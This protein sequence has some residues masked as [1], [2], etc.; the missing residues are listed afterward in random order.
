[1]YKPWN[2]PQCLPSSTTFQLPAA[3]GAAPSTPAPVPSPAPRQQQPVARP[4]AAGRPGRPGAGGAV[5]GEGEGR[6]VAQ[7]RVGVILTGKMGRDQAN[8]VPKT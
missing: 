5:G 7:G 1:M 6:D 3:A 4:P 8:I 2:D